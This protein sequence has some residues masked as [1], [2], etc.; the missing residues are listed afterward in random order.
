[1]LIFYNVS[2]L[3]L[4]EPRKIRWTTYEKIKSMYRTKLKKKLIILSFNFNSQ[5]TEDL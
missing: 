3:V 1:M 5:D 2:I 4:N